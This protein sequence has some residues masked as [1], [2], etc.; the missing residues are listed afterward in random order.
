MGQFHCYGLRGLLRQSF[1]RRGKKKA[2][3][4][5]SLSWEQKIRFPTGGAVLFAL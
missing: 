3:K 1:V 2:M 4:H 5:F